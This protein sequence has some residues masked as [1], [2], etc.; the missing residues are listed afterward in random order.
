M[1]DGCLGEDKPDTKKGLI[2]SSYNVTLNLKRLSEGDTL[3]LKKAIKDK[4]GL[5]FNICRQYKDKR[6]KHNWYYLR[7][8]C[9]EVDR[10]MD[11]VR[12]HILPSFAY[13]L[14]DSNG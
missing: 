1:C 6:R 14:K 13:K 4:L 10:F 11:I 3:M 2:N 7:L 12:P 9:K 8:P 5:D